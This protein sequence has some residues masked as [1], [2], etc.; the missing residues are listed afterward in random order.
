MQTQ[1]MYRKHDKRKG[2]RLL[3]MIRQF[4]IFSVYILIVGITGSVLA[5][6]PIVKGKGLCDPQVRV[7]GDKAY[8]YATHDTSPNNKGFR[9]DDW[10]VWSSS[11]LIN[12]KY[13]SSLKPEDTYFG[14]PNNSCW[15]T[16]AARR[17]GKYYFYFSMGRSNVGVVVSD[18]PTGPWKDPL[19][20]PL[21]SENLTPTSE[22]DPGI[23]SDD[24]G[25]A[26]IV[27]GVWDF[28]IA[29]LNDDMISLAETPR[30]IKLDQIMG[31]YGSGKTDDK[32]FLHKRN[33]KYYLSW[34]CYYAMSDNVYGPYVYKGS[35]IIKDRVA[36]EFQDTSTHDSYD[37]ITYDRHGSFF[38][39]HN[40]WY[41]IYND[42]SLPGSTPYFR[43]SVISYVH[44]R[45]NGEME[46][47][48]LDT[49]GVGRYTAALPPLQAENYFNVVGANKRE[50]SE[51]GFE[52]CDIHD[53]SY[54]LYPNVMNLR[55]KSMI[56]FHLACGNPAGGA[57]EIRANS[58]NG[59]LL[60]LCK[61]PYTEGWTK[62]KTF[63]CRLRSKSEKEN[64][65]LYF[66][67]GKG[68]LARL[69]WLSFR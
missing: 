42:Q 35:V 22:R 12:W 23:L 18:S 44:Y 7:Y 20:K 41:Y 50:C 63:E 40:Q 57:I 32:P 39:M 53:G 24:D 64:I 51:G 56:S 16:D 52:I 66:R 4:F 47:V 26:Y 10:W 31:P 61:I 21:L 59:K 69:D 17:N 43:N 13:E 28:Y 29:R 3:S 9:M 6:N 68:E 1:L 11:D 65:C 34:G 48:Y 46:P 33:G 37:F 2:Y 62:Y 54:L 67:G 14:K 27:F 55:P 45:N 30:K 58:I 25:N 49:L 60:G 36:K 38:E 5:Q 15:A 8:L 19:G